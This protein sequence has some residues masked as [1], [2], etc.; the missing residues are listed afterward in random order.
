MRGE[1]EEE[2]KLLQK[3]TALRPAV[4]DFMRLATSSEHLDLSAEQIEA[5]PARFRAEAES[6]NSATSPTEAAEAKV[7]FKSASR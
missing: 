2:L 5:L 6:R 1:H 3:A 4:V 7:R